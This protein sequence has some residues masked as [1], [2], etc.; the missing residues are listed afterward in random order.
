MIADKLDDPLC[1]PFWRAAQEHRLELCWC[2]PCDAA[3]WYPLA[4]CPKCAAPTQWH[5]LSGRASLHSWSEVLAPI[6]PAFPKPYITGL[7]VPEEAPGTRLVTQLVDCTA[8]D[9][10]CD[11][12]LEACFRPLA[13]QDRD[14]CLAPVFKPAH[15][16]GD[17][18]L[19]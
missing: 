9:L 6:N 11:M 16:Y 7:V 10:R 5:Q 13:G 18:R 2:G 15:L 12:P 8:A 3:V 17:Q 19:P 1:G 14:G 4:H